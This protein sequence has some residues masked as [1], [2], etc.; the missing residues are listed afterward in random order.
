VNERFAA[1]PAACTSSG[2][3]KALI[4][5]FGVYSGRYLA[6]YPSDWEKRLLEHMATMPPVEQS[7]ASAL[8]R[9]LKERC[10]LVGA[11][12]LLW[13][14]NLPWLTNAELCIERRISNLSGLIVPNGTKTTPPHEFE[15]DAF[16]PP[17]TAEEEFKSV[18]ENYVRVCELILLTGRELLFIDPYLNPIEHRVAK[19]LESML[20]TCASTRSKC[21]LVICFAKRDHV[22]D[23]R[24][25]TTWSEVQ[26]ELRTIHGRVVG[27]KPFALRYVLVEDARSSYQMHERYLVSVKGGI[28]LSKGFQEQAGYRKVKANPMSPGLHRSIWSMFRE[29]DADFVV[30][31]QINIE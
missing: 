1:D 17:P 6:N 13:D 15:L 2:D 20:A 14:T 23:I 3:L 18:K 7:R 12:T 4:E 30:T 10:G 28:E 25:G 22:L 19:V 24:R 5:K 29:G 9:R 31:N 27:N 21:D 26:R 16:D 11:S 8:L